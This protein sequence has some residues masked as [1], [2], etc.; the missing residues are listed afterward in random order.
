MACVIFDL[1]RIIFAFVL[2]IAATCEMS[3]K[4]KIPTKFNIYK[5]KRRGKYWLAVGCVCD[6]S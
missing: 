2:Q 4:E 5:I 3:C 6:I 1:A